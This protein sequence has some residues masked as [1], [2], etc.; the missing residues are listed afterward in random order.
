M[1]QQFYQ[2]ALKGETT[3]FHYPDIDPHVWHL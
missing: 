2:R 1:M 3:K